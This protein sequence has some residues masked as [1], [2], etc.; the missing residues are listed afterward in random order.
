[1]LDVSTGSTDLGTLSG[2]FLQVGIALKI[3]HANW[4]S[5]IPMT[6]PGRILQVYVASLDFLLHLYHEKDQSF[7]FPSLRTAYRYSIHEGTGSDSGVW[8]ILC[9]VRKRFSN[10]QLRFISGL[11]DDAAR[12]ASTLCRMKQG[13]LSPCMTGYS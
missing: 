12:I 7:S 10:Y 4:I 1:M 3:W 2:P 8:I 5:V 11:A 13:I 6:G 9:V